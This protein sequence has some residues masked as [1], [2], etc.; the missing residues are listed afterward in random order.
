MIGPNL[1]RCQHF[2]LFLLSI[3]VTTCFYLVVMSKNRV[4]D[5]PGS[6]KNIF[7]AFLYCYRKHCI[8]TFSLKLWQPI[9]K[10]PKCWGEWRLSNGKTSMV[11]SHRLPDT[12]FPSSLLLREP[13][14]QTHSVFIDTFLCFCHSSL[15][16]F[17]LYPAKCCQYFCVS[18]EGS[19]DYALTSEEY[20]SSSV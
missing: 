3:L 18:T 13:L 16:F 1:E 2:H 12:Q 8:C 20:A 4:F 14:G 19:S 10:I 15:P 5:Y 17:L 7:V 9:F 11:A 6:E